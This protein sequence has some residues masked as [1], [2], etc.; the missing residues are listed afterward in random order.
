MQ[1]RVGSRA[2]VTPIFATM[3]RRAAAAAAA[4]GTAAMVAAP[5][6]TADLRSYAASAALKPSIETLEWTLNDSAVWSAPVLTAAMETSNGSA[7]WLDLD[8]GKPTSRETL[9]ADIVTGSF[10]SSRAQTACRLINPHELAVA[11][12]LG[13]TAGGGRGAL[14]EPHASDS[15]PT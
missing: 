15:S 11:Y 14:S 6:P 13:S 8:M 12:P 7:L 10:G 4:V 9:G 3:L 2:A 5:A 1:H